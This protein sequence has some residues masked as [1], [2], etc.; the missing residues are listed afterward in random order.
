[1]EWEILIVTEDGVKIIT[2]DGSIALDS[3]TD[4]FTVK[5]SN[6]ETVIQKGICKNE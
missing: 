2:K 4:S 6:G 1:M 5:N 3:L